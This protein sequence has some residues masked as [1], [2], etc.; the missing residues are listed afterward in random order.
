MPVEGEKRPDDV[1]DAAIIGK[2]HRHPDILGR[3]VLV[4]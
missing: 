3:S 4:L 1:I 2:Q